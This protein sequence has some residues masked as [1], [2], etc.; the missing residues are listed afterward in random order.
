MPLSLGIWACVNN[1]SFFYARHVASPLTNH[2][3]CWVLYPHCLVTVSVAMLREQLF[4][5]NNKLTRHVSHVR[6]AVLSVAAGAACSLDSRKLMHN[7]QATG[8]GCTMPGT[9]V[10]RERSVTELLLRTA[11]LSLQSLN[12]SGNDQTPP[13]ALR[14]KVLPPSGQLIELLACE[15]SPALAGLQHAAV[16][17]SQLEELQHV[18]KDWPQ[19]AASA[20]ATL[21]EAAGP[22]RT[23]GIGRSLWIY[24]FSVMTGTTFAVSGKRAATASRKERQRA[25]PSLLCASGSAWDPACPQ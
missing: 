2:S 16:E 20:P 21:D 4:G 24:V 14:L 10:V 6:G 12:P 22:R 13:Q 5:N 8:Q 19:I 11:S 18:A 3:S 17:G 23:A 9:A 25:L 1:G 15:L 7:F